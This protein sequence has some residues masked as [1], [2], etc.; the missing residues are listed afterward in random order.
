MGNMAKY[1]K[2]QLD[3]ERKVIVR[4]DNREVIEGS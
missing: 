1:L 2:V 4:F 3:E